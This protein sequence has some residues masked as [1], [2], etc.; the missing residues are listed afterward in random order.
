MIGKLQCVVLDCPHALGLAGF[1]QALL[2]GELNRPDPRWSWADE[3]DWATLHLESG[4]VLAFQRVQDFHAPRWSDPGHPQQAHLDVSVTD[5]ERAHRE[6]LNAGATLL[7]DG[8]GTR[9]WRVY[10][11]PVGHPLCLIVE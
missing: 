5:L 9:S 8:G 2:G 6:A 4:M 1:Y 7:D 11:D 10:A 3:G